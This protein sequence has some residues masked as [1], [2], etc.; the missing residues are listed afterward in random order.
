MNLYSTL[1]QLFIHKS[2]QKAGFPGRRL[3]LVLKRKD[4]NTGLE[5][6]WFFSDPDI[7]IGLWRRKY[8]TVS[9]MGL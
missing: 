3:E 7:S 5:S 1:P 2:N 4:H 6:F 8:G 9:K